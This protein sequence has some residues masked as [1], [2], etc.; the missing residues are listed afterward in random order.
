MLHLAS[1]VCLLNESRNQ[2]LLA[3]QAQCV[4]IVELADKVIARLLVNGKVNLGR[5]TASYGEV[6]DSVL[7]VE[8]LDSCQL[9]FCKAIAK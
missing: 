1:D 8:C 5:G 6:R 2:A 9:R 4:Q 7:V 3:S